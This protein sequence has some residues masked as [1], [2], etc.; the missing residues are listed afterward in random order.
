MN[1]T[2]LSLA[3]PQVRVLE[4][5]GLDSVVFVWCREHVQRVF[6]EGVFLDLALVMTLHVLSDCR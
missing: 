1:A 4:E 3:E 2:K 5:R 6:C